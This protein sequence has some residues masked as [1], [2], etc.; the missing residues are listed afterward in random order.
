MIDEDFVR[1]KNLIIFVVLVL[2]TLL[3]TTSLFAQRI[4]KQKKFT[5]KKAA[6]LQP[7]VGKTNSSSSKPVLQCTS[8]NAGDKQATYLVGAGKSSRAEEKRIKEKWGVLTIPQGETERAKEIRKNAVTYRQRQ[9]DSIKRAFEI[10]QKLNPNATQEE[11][12]EYQ[13]KYQESLDHFSDGKLEMKVGQNKWDWR[14]FLDVGPVMNQGEGCNTCWAFAATSAA[15]SSIQKNYLDQSGSWNLFVDEQTGMLINTVGGITFWE[16]N[17]GPF[18]QTLLNC[19]PIRKEEI[20]RSGWHGTAFDFMVYRQ[21]IPTIYEDGFQKK[22]DVTGKTVTYRRI[23]NPGQKFACQP[24]GGFI[25]G[26]AWDYVNSPPD[27]LPTVEQL[28]TA[29]IE[30]GPLAAP[31]FYD[32]CLANYRGGVFNEEDLGQINHVVL[33]VGWDDDK[34]AWLVK[35]SWGED[36]GEKGFAWIKYGS[37]NI[38]VFAAWIE[39]SDNYKIITVFILTE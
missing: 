37:N 14:E 23:Y 18:A 24:N 4:Q 6:V 29:L 25:K 11:I 12:N 10:W 38:G 1:M 9:I 17:P 16:G 39:A 31:I 5:R 19:M 35:N 8:R 28:K 21:G 34:G 3:I 22:N 33:L 2:L 15:D 7:Q 36:W 20:C 27:K 30:H 32:D 13:K 26:N